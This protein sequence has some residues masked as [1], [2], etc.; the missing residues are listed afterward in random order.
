MRDSALNI[1]MFAYILC[2]L[3]F[4]F[5]SPSRITVSDWGAGNHENF[6]R[7]C[8]PHLGNNEHSIR[9]SFPGGNHELSPRVFFPH[10]GNN[11]HSIRTSFPVGNHE[12]S[13]RVI[14]SRAQH[15]VESRIYHCTT[16][17]Y[18]T[19]SRHRLGAMSTSFK[20]APPTLAEDAKEKE[21]DT[22]KY[23]T[24]SFFCLAPDF[25]S[26]FFDKLTKEPTSDEERTFDAKVHA[27][28]VNVC[29]KHPIV[30]DILRTLPQKS[31]RKAFLALDQHFISTSG[32]ATMRNLYSIMDRVIASPLNQSNIARYRSDFMFDVRNLERNGFSLPLFVQ[33]AVVLRATREDTSSLW[34]QL[35]FEEQKDANVAESLPFLFKKLEDVAMQT[36]TDSSSISES[37]ATSDKPPARPFRKHEQ[38]SKT[39]ERGTCSHCSK[40]GKINSHRQSECWQLHPEK[41]PKQRG[42]SKPDSKATSHVTTS[43]PV[44]GFEMEFCFATGGL[45]DIDVPKGHE[46]PDADVDYIDMPALVPEDDDETV[47]MPVPTSNK[48]EVLQYTH[49]PPPPTSKPIGNVAVSIMGLR[50]S[51]V[52]WF[53]AQEQALDICMAYAA[54]DSFAPGA[55]K[56]LMDNGSTQHVV[57]T[58]DS[59][60]VDAATYKPF[61]PGQGV[62][63]GAGLG[64]DC[65]PL[66]TVDLA[67][68]VETAAG[69]TVVLRF[70]GALYAPTFKTNVVS[71]A[72]VV[73]QGLNYSTSGQHGPH[74][75]LPAAGQAAH[76][77]DDSR[78]IP[79]QVASNGL[80]HF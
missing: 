2:I 40:L 55:E 44:A 6:P 11:E 41:K 46:V 7:V 60:F 23:Q 71:E 36:A 48:C 1:I 17:L 20:M 78:C 21:Y 33:R 3:A 13:P 77:S 5:P 79:L 57:N 25:D 49:L 63:L 38:K 75:E 8:F 66:G 65:R 24:G 69:T 18:Q 74:L 54:G 28:L 61:P 76:L 52:S 31:G 29:N 43:T 35:R 70:K 32:A 26:N 72:Q 42:A 30:T 37:F 64:N 19:A 56:L 50:Q 45:C 73:K 27:Y 68:R 53:Q 4:C 12:L 10:P 16:C 22:F 62:L 15:V 14:S 67:V 58:L 9:T 51:P 39:T 59:S 34:V 47:E 80:R